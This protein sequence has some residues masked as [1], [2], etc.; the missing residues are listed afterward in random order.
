ML[1]AAI[2]SPLAENATCATCATCATYFL[3][4]PSM[5]SEVLL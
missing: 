1:G 4:R 2:G 3:K 5:Y